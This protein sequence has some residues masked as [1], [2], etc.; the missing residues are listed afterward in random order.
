MKEL[1]ENHVFFSVTT[2]DGSNNGTFKVFTII[3]IPTQ[4]Y[5]IDVF[6]AQTWTDSRLRF[7]STM[8]ILTLN[9]NMVGLI[10]IP[11]TIFRNSKTAEAHWIT[12]PN[13]LLR[14]WNDGKILY[15]LRLTINAECQL[16]LHNFPMDEH[17]CPLIFSSCQKL[18]GKNQRPRQQWENLVVDVCYRQPDPGEPID[19]VF[20]LELLEKYSQVLVLLRDFNHP[21]ICWESSM[22][23]CRQSRRLMEHMENNFL[24]QVI[25]SPTRG[26]AMVIN[27]TE[28]VGSIK[29]GSSLGY[30]GP[31]LVEFAVL[32]DMGQL[33]NKVRTLN[34]R[35]GNVQ[36][37]KELFSRNLWHT[38]LRDRTGRSLRTFSIEY[39]NS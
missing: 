16:Q 15:T 18:M 17:S 30:S 28:L 23:S 2:T 10:W 12:T 21:Y 4:E 5:Q 7:N 37:F 34:F 39:Q 6:F 26:D 27:T 19:E 31:A 29:I 33:K 36:L 1:V 3:I 14:I 35:K 8:K 20:L 25:D 22:V 38:A 24:S 13:Q 32:R 11:D 9:S